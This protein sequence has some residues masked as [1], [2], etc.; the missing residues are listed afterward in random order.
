M[1]WSSSKTF[2]ERK[3]LGHPSHWWKSQKICGIACQLI[4]SLR[5]TYLDSLLKLYPH[6]SNLPHVVSLG[7][8]V[9][10]CPNFIKLFWKQGTLTM[11]MRSISCRSGL[12]FAAT[13]SMAAFNSS[14][15][16]E[17]NAQPKKRAVARHG[18]DKYSAATGTWK[19]HV[20]HIYIYIH[21]IQ[22]GMAIRWLWSCNF[23]L[24]CVSLDQVVSSCQFWNKCWRMDEVFRKSSHT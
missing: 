22:Y 9:I 2:H 15:R 3:I 5:G 10:F 14:I 11:P 23:L 20:L 1:T 18:K 7:E 17:K 8:V 16:W 12:L 13:S 19:K 4:R 24:L 21:S 6:D